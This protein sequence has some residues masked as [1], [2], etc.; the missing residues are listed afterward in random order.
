MA[1]INYA[2]AVDALQLGRLMRDAIGRNDAAGIRQII[3]DAAK[4]QSTINIA[5]GSLNGREMDAVV[6]AVRDTPL[7]PVFAYHL[8]NQERPAPLQEVHHGA[9]R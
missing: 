5:Y 2:S 6:A 4:R 1:R 7:W 8:A 3:G 9:V